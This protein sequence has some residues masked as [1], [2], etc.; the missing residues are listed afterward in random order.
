MTAEQHPLWTAPHLPVATTM[1]MARPWG[2]QLPGGVGGPTGAALNRIMRPVVHDMPP[3]PMGR[4][5]AQ[6][7][8]VSSSTASVYMP[9]PHGAGENDAPGKRRRKTAPVASPGFAGYPCSDEE[10]E[11]KRHKNRQ[12]GGDGLSHGRWTK[13]VGRSRGALL[14][15]RRLDAPG[16]CHL[17]RA[18]PPSPR[19]PMAHRAAGQILG[20]MYTPIALGC[21]RATCMPPRERPHQLGM[22]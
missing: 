4:W 8:S 1:P 14:H 16:V 6:A 13:E 21:S 19:A 10:V 11:P 3:R 17:T 7:V 22:L 18:Y 2:A 15:M 20:L 5:N 12:K 9:P